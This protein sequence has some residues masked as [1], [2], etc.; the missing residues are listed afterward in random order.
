MN[1]ETVSGS[2]APLETQVYTLE[3]SL[4]QLAADGPKAD[5]EKQNYPVVLF[6]KKHCNKAVKGEHAS[7]SMHL[8]LRLPLQL[9]K[10]G[11]T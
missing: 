1:T 3:G 10:A 4:C 9:K 7:T 8:K 2:G 6:F 5:T 11:E